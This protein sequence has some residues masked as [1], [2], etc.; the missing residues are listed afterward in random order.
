MSNELIPYPA[1][2]AVVDKIEA[3]HGITWEEVEEVFRNCPRLF[4]TQVADQYG[5]SR[6]DAMGRT[7]AGRYVIAFFVMMP[8]NFAKVIS[9]REMTAKERR[10]YGRK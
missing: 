5:E 7:D 2:P 6:Y 3:K 8:D 10:R 1:S 9:A 4:L